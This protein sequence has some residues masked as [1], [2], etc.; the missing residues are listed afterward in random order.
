VA[1][2]DTPFHATMARKRNC[3]CDGTEMMTSWLHLP[4]P[5]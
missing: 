4:L 3:L 1:V 5:E 2:F